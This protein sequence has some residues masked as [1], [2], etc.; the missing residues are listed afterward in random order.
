MFQQ[1]DFVKLAIANLTQALVLGFILVVVILALFLFEWRMALI[2]LLTIPLSLVATMLVLYWRG[3]TINTMT[4]A[5]LVIALGAVVDDAIIDVENITRRLREAPAGRRRPV[6]RRGD[7]RRLPRGAQPDR[8]RHAHHRR[9]VGPGLPAGRADRGV[10][11]AAR[12]VLHARD[13]RLD[14]GRAH[15]HPGAGP[16][17]CCAARIERRKSPLVGWLQRATP[18]GCRGSSSGPVAAYATVGLV[19]ILGVAVYPQ[20]GQSLFPAFKERDFLIHWVSPPGTSA[21]EME[22]SDHQISKELLAIPGVQSAGAHI[23]QALLGE[24]VAGVNLGEIWVSLDDS[25]D[26]TRPSAR[27]RPSPTDTRACSARSRPTSTSGSTRCSPAARNPS[28]CASTARTWTSAG[29][30][31]PDPRHPGGRRGRDG[32]APRHLLGRPAGRGAP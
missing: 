7:P 16:A 6:H 30:I 32:R 10:L 9:G 22:R 17:V 21:A 13:R 15:R 26:Y 3:A 12:A 29:E 18:R 24:E 20:L 4:L 1:A 2:S 19:T 23:G 27:S 28:S 31:R 5:G 14:G 25:A 11:P 8:L